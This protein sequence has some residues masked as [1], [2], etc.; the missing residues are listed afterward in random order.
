MVKLE[1]A[2]VARYRAKG[3]NF[4]ILI[5]P[6]AAQKIKN[7]EPVN[8]LENLAADAVFRDSAKGTRASEEALSKTFGTIELEKIA[9]EI[10]LKGELQVTTEQRRN[11]IES[12]RKQIIAA[13]AREAVDPRTNLPHPI[14]RIELALEEAKVRIDPFKPVEAQLKDVLDALKPI[15]PIKLEKITIEIKVEGAQYGKIYSHIKAVGALRKEEWTRNGFW[16]CQLEIPAGLQTELYDKLNQ[17][18]KGS[19]ETRIVK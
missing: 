8:V 11:L 4:E 16:I 18:T 2:V 12:K 6:E 19:V 15:L 14:R 10:V 1:D 9:R 5:A 13:I 7:N 17:L 3:E